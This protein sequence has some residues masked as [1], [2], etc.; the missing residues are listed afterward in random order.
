MPLVCEIIVPANA[1]ESQA[2]LKVAGLSVLKR[3]VLGACRAGFQQIA[4]N[5]S[6]A[7]AIVNGQRKDR[8]TQGVTINS[9]LS[10]VDTPRLV[11][12][13]NVVLGKR[14]YSHRERRDSNIG[15]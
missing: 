13:A 6:N 4:I 14:L 9:N 1:G 15:T 3:L 8:R 7:D 12:N 10:E 2:L 11:V 5:A